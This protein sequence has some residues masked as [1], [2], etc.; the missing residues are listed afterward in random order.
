MH[1]ELQIKPL[2]IQPP[3]VWRHHHQPHAFCYT[4]VKIWRTNDPL[5]GSLSRR[6]AR[7]HHQ[8]NTYTSERTHGKSQLSVKSKN[9][10]I[11][12]PVSLLELSQSC[13]KKVFPL[14]LF[15]IGRY[16]T[17]RDVRPRGVVRTNERTLMCGPVRGSAL[18]IYMRV[19]SPALLIHNHA[20]RWVWFFL[21]LN[22]FADM[23]AII[24]TIS[25]WATLIMNVEK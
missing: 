15:R 10:L 16:I 25:D 24:I 17:Y 8:Q 4:A 12:R 9:D 1:L 13:V 5:F 14:S 7:I 18:N 3:R 23:T 6:K 21:R 20:M 22:W 11:T 2:S 19:R